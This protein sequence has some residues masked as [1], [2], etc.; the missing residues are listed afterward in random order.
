MGTSSSRALTSSRM[1]DDLD[2]ESSKIN[3]MWV[4]LIGQ[5]ILIKSETVSDRSL[6]V[7]SDFESS[8]CTFHPLRLSTRFGHQ[9]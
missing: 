2:L 9:I 1:S 3:Q 4:H 7:R 8:G 5:V 6:V